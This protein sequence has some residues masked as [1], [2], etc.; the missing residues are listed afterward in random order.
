MDSISFFF[1]FISKLNFGIFY[2]SFSVFSER[3]IYLG[4]NKDHIIYILYIFMHGPASCLRKEEDEAET[5]I[6]LCCSISSFAVPVVT[7]RIHVLSIDHMLTF[8]PHLDQRNLTGISK[9][10]KAPLV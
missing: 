4:A 1:L 9:D 10:L 8:S 2:V 3:Y 7:T 5:D 6:M